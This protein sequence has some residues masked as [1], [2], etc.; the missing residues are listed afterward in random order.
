[1]GCVACSLSFPCAV[2]AW[3]LHLQR[4]LL[5]V[6]SQDQPLLRLR[7]QQVWQLQHQQRLSL[8]LL[9]YW[10]LLCYL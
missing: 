9:L 4:L 8:L 5:Y 2:A 1:M 10:C 3:L 7:Q 6:Q